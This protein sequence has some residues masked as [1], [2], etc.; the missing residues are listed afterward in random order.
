[1]TFIRRQINDGAT[2]HDLIT[3]YQQGGDIESLSSLFQ[4]YLELI[5]GVC[6]KYL[7]DEDAGKDA[8]MEIFEVLLEKLKS[9]QIENFR[10]W[11]YSV[12][13]N[14]C[15]QILRKQKQYPVTIDLAG[16][17]YSDEILHH[18]IEF[19]WYDDHADL[20]ACIKD[21][22][23]AQRTTIEWFYMEKKSY[24]EIAAILKV[25]KDQVRSHIQNGRRNL[26]TCMTKKNN[27]TPS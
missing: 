26:K 12:T 19:D 17:V 15:L 4:R 20:Y 3:R 24:E 11:L 16:A 5:Y 1:M 9:H 22:P 14:H 23:D 10:S 13:K 25:S 2:D 21:L 27:G 18:D 7:K 6:L 8:A